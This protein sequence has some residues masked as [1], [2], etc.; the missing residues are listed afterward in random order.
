MLVIIPFVLWQQHTKGK[1]D[2]P[3]GWFQEV[4]R[5]ATL[6]EFCIMT[7]LTGAELWK[8]IWDKLKELCDWCPSASERTK[9]LFLALY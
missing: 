1:F 8:I 7:T 2:P 5:K 4:F 6:G 9:R 3:E